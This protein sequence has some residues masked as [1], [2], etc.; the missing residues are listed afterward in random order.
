MKIKR[1]YFAWCFAF[2]VLLFSQIVF[3][4]DDQY[5]A[6][7]VR[8]QKAREYLFNTPAE[9]PLSKKA[10]A[11]FKGLPYFDIQP[12]YR[13][14]AKF[15][16]SADTTPFDMP[17]FFNNG[18]VKHIKLGTLNFT[19]NGK[20]YSLGVYQRAPQT[21]GKAIISNSYA[22]IAFRDLTNGVETYEGGRYIDLGKR[23]SETVTLDFNL[24]YT[25]DCAYNKRFICP[26]PPDE[27]RLD[28]RV[29][30][31]EKL[32]R[33]GASTEK[34]KKNNAAKETAA[35]KQTAATETPAKPKENAVQEMPPKKAEPVSKNEEQPAENRE[36]I[37]NSSV[38]PGSSRFADF[39]GVKVHYQSFGAGDEAL[40]F[41]HGWTVSL[42]SWRSQLNAFP[43]LR[44]VA[45][46]LPGHGQSDKPQTDYTMEYF[47]RAVEAVM[48]DAGVKKAVLVG[49]SM[50]TPVIR[51]FYRL[52]PK[53]TLALVIVDGA[54]R[55]MVTKQEMEQFTSALR[56]N[57]K[58]AAPKMIDG[59]LQPIKDEKLKQ[60][61]RAIMLATPEHV[62]LSA[63][64]G[65]M[66]E[67]IYTTDKIKVPVLAI[68]AQSP[69][70]K[71]D[72][73]QFYR[74]IA[75]NIDFRMWRDASH[76]LM[77]EKPELFNQSIRFFLRI[78]NLLQN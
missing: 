2:I 53:K 20:E 32:Y 68:L 33:E 10:I 23:V 34:P 54:L 67:T 63:M 1:I 64:N 50:G 7:V 39:D 8:F 73:E 46:D 26:I 61:I 74:T 12:T 52:F 11:N 47:A 29:E 30:A 43:N 41:V 14:T 57:Y 6:S 36:R 69:F 56:A 70:W 75:P 44:V 40:I 49:H 77:M 16:P 25:P 18:M 59:M 55:P 31:G 78:N 21:A 45:V 65:M 76:F 22:F 15:T 24:A 19:L 38:P 13:V 9:S 48:R 71:P 66:D 51:Q 42:D 60:D 5:V 35:T 58:E 17:T 3:A 62:A 28:A 72:T 27:N 37:A 4:Q